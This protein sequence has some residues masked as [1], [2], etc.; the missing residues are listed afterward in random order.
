MDARAL[1]VLMLENTVTRIR[2]R[3]LHK[4]LFL[5]KLKAAEPCDS[6]EESEI[7]PLTRNSEP[8]ES[9]FSF[10]KINGDSFTRAATTFKEASHILSNDQLLALYKKRLNEVERLV[11]QTQDEKRSIQQ[12]ER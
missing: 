12:R 7:T 1:G 4:E 6:I 3:W 5:A 2:T 9:S 8:N 10:K 11:M